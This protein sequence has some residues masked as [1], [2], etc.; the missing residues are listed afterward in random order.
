MDISIPNIK[1]L[2]Y[3]ELDFPQFTGRFPRPNPHWIRN[4]SSFK[5]KQDFNIIVDFS[6]RSNQFPNLKSK[7]FKNKSM[8]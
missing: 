4:P 6:L 8:T 3:F 2:K 7:F 5:K 1:S